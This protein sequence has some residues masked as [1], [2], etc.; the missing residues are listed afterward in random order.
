M[1]HSLSGKKIALLIANGFDQADMTAAQ[2]ALIEK[3]ANVRIVSPETGL[4]NGWD[5]TSWG[6]NFAVD[7]ALNTA[8]GA[9]F[10]MVVVPGGERSSN[11]LKL[12][13][14]SKRFLGSFMNAGKPVCIMGDALALMVFTD[15]L[16]G[17]TVDGPD[18]LAA[19]ATQVNAVW[20]G[21][22][23]ICID[24][25]LMTGDITDATRSVFVEAMLNHFMGSAAEADLVTSKAA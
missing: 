9:D 7:Q 19:A 20:E 17:R 13:A 14:H 1:S 21:K 23:V 4:V 12:T 18:A 16:T 10:D 15:L 24:G 6:H 22:G 25:N 8:L 2:R 11:K 5:N 3:G